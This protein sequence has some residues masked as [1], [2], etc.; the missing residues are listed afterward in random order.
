MLEGKVVKVR[1]VKSYT[2]AH[3]HLAVGDV[4]HETPQ[5]LVLLCRT[6]HFGSHIGGQ[7]GTLR[8]GEYVCGVL[9]GEKGVRVIPWNRIEVINELPAKTNWNVKVQIDQSG[10]CYLA[11]EQKTVIS[12][13]PERV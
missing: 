11:N 9:E 2:T 5:Y 12:R 8:Q 4:L 6:Y 1:W 7:K 10:T 3:N 13:P